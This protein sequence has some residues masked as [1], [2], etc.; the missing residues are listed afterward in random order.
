MPSDPPQE[1]GKELLIEGITD[2]SSDDE[3]VETYEDIFGTWEEFH[4]SDEIRGSSFPL[5]ESFQMLSCNMIGTSDS[6]KLPKKNADFR[7]EK[8]L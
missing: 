6:V 7:K 2:S 1:K 4:E 5:E 8:R 3:E